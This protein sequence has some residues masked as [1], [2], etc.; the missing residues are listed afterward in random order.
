MVL[1]FWVKCGL[2]ASG[3]DPEAR[4]GNDPIAQKA[5]Y[6]MEK[7]GPF[8]HS[9]LELFVGT[10]WMKNAGVQSLGIIARVRL[11]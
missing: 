4:M 7:G 5:K 2:P 3:N 10:L 11:S 6:M 9:A 8:F 1:A